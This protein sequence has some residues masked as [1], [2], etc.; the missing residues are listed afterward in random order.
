MGKL[1]TLS[2]S[3]ILLVAFASTAFTQLFAGS[4][5]VSGTSPTGETYDGTVRISK[6]GGC[7]MQGV[8]ESMPVNAA[9]F[10]RGHN[11]KAAYRR[12]GRLVRVVYELTS[13]G[14]LNG[15]WTIAGTPG[16]GHEVLTPYA[17]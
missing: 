1:L 14:S 4:Y 17:R 2:F 8:I 10:P 15:S 13:D 16:R 11:L 5:R 9:C 3:A 12:R 7:R 6:H